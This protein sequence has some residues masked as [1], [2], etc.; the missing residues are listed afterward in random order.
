[1]EY[2]LPRWKTA[3][4][5]KVCDIAGEKNK[6]KIKI[7]LETCPAPHFLSAGQRCD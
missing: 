4:I 7:K 1:V 6:I 3:G 5:I 2:C